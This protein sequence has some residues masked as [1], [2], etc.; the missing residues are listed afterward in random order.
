MDQTAALR[1]R[2][3]HALLLDTRDGSVRHLPFDLGAHGLALLVIDTRAPHR[4]VDGQYA[5]RRDTCNAAALHLG[6]PTL[7]E[8]DADALDDALAALDGELVT[9]AG[10][11]ASAGRAARP[12]PARRHRDRPGRA[13]RGAAGEPGGSPRSA[14]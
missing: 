12:H 14:R 11:T 1:A 4:L 6:V 13:V 5:R 7:R 9:P 2:D 3:G 8:V 10:A